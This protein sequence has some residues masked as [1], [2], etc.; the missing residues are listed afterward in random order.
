MK[1]FSGTVFSLS[2][3]AMGV[4]AQAQ[5]PAQDLEPN[6]FNEGP[7]LT[8]PEREALN[9]ELLRGMTQP[10]LDNLYSHLTSGSMP[11]GTYD[12]YVVFDNTGEA[13]VERILA[14]S[15]PPQLVN[16]AKSF[17]TKLWRGKTIDG[18]TRTLTNRMGPANRF[19]AAIYCGQSLL[20]SRRESI[21]LDYEFGDSLASYVAALDWPMTRYGLSIRDELRMVQ[22]GLY[23]GRAYIRGLFAVNFILHNEAEEQ[24]GNWDDE[25]RS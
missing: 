20:D 23:L 11:N 3:M 7:I 22:P 19:P 12:G 4:A 17:G 5:A 6:R 24:L 10:E 1:V 18:E 9:L 13:D 25:C 14:A 8:Q 2:L 16:W 15:A 21:I